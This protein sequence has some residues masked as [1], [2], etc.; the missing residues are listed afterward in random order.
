MESG[1]WMFRRQD[2]TGRITRVR[3][4]ATGTEVNLEGHDLAGITVEVASDVPG[5]SQVISSSQLSAMGALAETTVEFP[6]ALPPHAWVLLKRNMTWVDRR[7]LNWGYRTSA[8]EGIEEV[9]EPQ[10]QLDSL[11]SLGEGPSVEFKVE[12]PPL[13]P[14]NDELG[15]LR[16]VA[17]FAN[18]DGGTI[19]FGVADDGEAVG[20]TRSEVDG[21]TRDRVTTLVRAN[22]APLVAFSI[23]VFDV[24]GK[25]DK[26]VLGLSVETGPEPPYGVTRGGPSY[27]LR[28]GATTFPISPQEVRRLARSQ[29]PMA[30]QLKP[31]WG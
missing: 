5:E 27:Y 6:G 4:K 8:D 11:V 7:F 15:F 21:R 1:D 10:D 28:R 18:G 14:R 24:E 12:L 26:V 13:Q 31:P 17:A 23:D 9:V 16:T 2:T 22:V 25:P 20:L 3:L 30:P 19:L 29:P